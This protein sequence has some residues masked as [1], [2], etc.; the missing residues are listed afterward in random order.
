MNEVCGQLNDLLT[1]ESTTLSSYQKERL[2]DI[3][4]AYNLLFK[5]QNETFESYS[6]PKVSPFDKLNIWFRRTN[7]IEYYFL[8]TVDICTAQEV[9]IQM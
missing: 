5:R 4:L 6:Q 7:Y 9:H 1:Y 3:E 2:R 8:S